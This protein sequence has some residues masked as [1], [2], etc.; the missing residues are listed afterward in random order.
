MNAF[1]LLS[2]FERGRRYGW[3]CCGCTRSVERQLLGRHLGDYQLPFSVGRCRTAAVRR[4]HRAAAQTSTLRAE[5][6][7]GQHGPF[8]CR[9]PISNI[10]PA[11]KVTHEVSVRGAG[12]PLIE[13]VRFAE[14]SPLEEA[15]YEPSVPLYGGAKSGGEG[16]EHGTS[17]ACRREWYDP[18]SSAT[19]LRRKCRRE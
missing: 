13:K 3:Q 8:G 15:G 5:L 11:A 16:S 9:C 12:A 10:G 19:K 6:P 17:A 2:L 7:M 4:C 18:P 1:P 14:D